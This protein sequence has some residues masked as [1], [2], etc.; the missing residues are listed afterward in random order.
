MGHLADLAEQLAL[1]QVAA[2]RRVLGKTLDFQLIE[3]NDEMPN[4]LGRA[5]GLC[6]I[7]FSFRE[8]TRRNRYRKNGSTQ[9]LMRCM[10][11]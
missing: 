1:A 7:K 2:V 9:R 5:K 11:Q 3:R 6:L 4:T 10:Q 8:H